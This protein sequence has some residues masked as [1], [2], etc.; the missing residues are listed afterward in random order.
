[1][2]ALDVIKEQKLEV[3][4][5]KVSNSEWKREGSIIRIDPCPFCGHKGHFTIYPETNTFATFGSICSANV[6]GGSIID[7][8]MSFF[9]QDKAR[10]IQSLKE[11][12]FIRSHSETKPSQYDT[13]KIKE[14]IKKEKTRK[15]LTKL[16]DFC[17][18]N[19][20]QTN[21][22]RK[23]GLTTETIRRFNL[24]YNPNGGTHK[25]IIPINN[26]FVICR[27][28]GQEEPRYKNCG[29]ADVLLNE[30]YINSP[31]IKQIFIVEG[32][33]DC[34]SIEQSGF[35][36]IALNSTNNKG[37]LLNKLIESLNAQQD[38]HYI[39]IPD[40]DDGGRALVKYLE[41][42]FEK[43]NIKLTVSSI[44][45]TKYKDCND[46]LVDD[47]E[48]LND[49][50]TESLEHRDDCVSTYLD[51]FITKILDKSKKN[52]KIGTG[53]NKLDELLGG[54]IYPG[55]YAIGG[56]PSLG[57]TAFTLQ[58]ADFIAK[59]GTDVIFYSLEM[60]RDELI[61]RSLSR[62][63]S[64]MT[65]DKTKVKDIGTRQILDG[66]VEH[67]M[68]ELEIAKRE[69]S[70]TAKKLIIVEGNFNT[71]IDEIR[72]RTKKYI[73]ETGRHPVIVV[74]YLQIVRGKERLNDK[75]NADYIV[76]ELKR[77]SRDLHLPVIA[78]SSFNRASYSNT[79]GFESFKE[80]G[81]IEYG[82]DVVIGLE[83]SILKTLESP[84]GYDKKTRELIDSAK[85]NIPR[86]VDLII[87]KNRNGK[88]NIRDHFEFY[89]VNNY[90]RET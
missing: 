24:G 67:I 66:A 48:G 78:I 16:I 21:Y 18:K 47:P 83:L 77:I 86:Q 70:K 31:E 41:P 32:A 52:K 26:Y 71:G 57:K 36:A 53:F 42:E 29:D 38:K 80:S 25:L 11:F 17:K 58:V 84:K 8:Q 15:D 20:E 22:F 39:L 64:V 55:L 2:D 23:R 44:T 61:A 87:L 6:S 9:G 40:N 54:G 56:V 43:L 72:E 37:I 46:F 90:F 59:S 33:I 76:S 35:K 12:F 27:A 85:S 45:D 81:S 1:M 14:P 69:Y 19:I 50:L 49:F 82:S 4:I 74:D 10:A 5:S 51:S 3:Y 28:E 73:E 88:T 7:F 89:P 13:R 62:E 60:S 34:M 63:I 75:Q 68:D 30:K 65:K 79:V